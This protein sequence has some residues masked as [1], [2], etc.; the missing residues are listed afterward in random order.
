MC[1]IYRLVQ[2]LVDALDFEVSQERF[3]CCHVERTATQPADKSK[4]HQTSVF[5]FSNGH[6]VLLETNVAPVLN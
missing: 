6:V 5:P 3:K 2:K 1:A 4:K